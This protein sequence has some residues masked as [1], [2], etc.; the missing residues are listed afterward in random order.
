MW[1]ILSGTVFQTYLKFSW[2]LQNQYKQWKMHFQDE[3]EREN[4][5]ISLI[6]EFSLVFISAAQPPY[7]LMSSVTLWS[8][9]PKGEYLSTNYITVLWSAGSSPVFYSTFVLNYNSILLGFYFSNLL[10]SLWT[11]CLFSKGVIILYY[12]LGIKN[13]FNKQ[14]I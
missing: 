12:Q 6:S 14:C 3:Y 5:A 13:E 1:L 7:Y 10:S 4:I 8:F 9:C 11:W 2:I